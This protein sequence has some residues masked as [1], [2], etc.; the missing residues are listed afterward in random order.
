MDRL[1]VIAELIEKKIISYSPQSGYN[2]NPGYD[3]LTF[4]ISYGFED[5][6]ISQQ[7]NICSSRL[8]VNTTTEFIRGHYIDV[9]LIAANMSTVVNADFIIKL[10]Q[11]GAFGI[12]HRAQS[13]EDILSDIKKVAEK[14]ELVAASIGIDEE[15]FE[16]AKEMITAG[17]NILTIDVA[18]SYTDRTIDLVKKIKA[19][20]KDTKIIVGNTTNIGILEELYDCLDAVKV[21][22]AQGYACETKNTAG[23]TEKQFSAVYKFKGLSK[24]L[25]IPVISDGSIKEPA[26][27]VKAI[28]AG[29]NSVMA[30]K[31]FAACPESAADMELVGDNIKTLKK[32]YAG[33]ASRYVQER[34]KGGL[35]KGTCP[36]GGIRYLDIGE[37]AEKLLERYVGALRSGI[38]YSGAID[39]D[40]FQKNVKFVRFK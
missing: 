2:I 32:V 36:E 25:G 31:I 27:M 40:S 17:C 24:Y 34:W 10:Y 8:E 16:L 3:Q 35:R 4:P 21:G 12:I 13:K 11:L 29:A 15:Q 30:G 5:V 7:K 20:S 23:C 33:M 18:N 26:D 14:C 37:P 39:I 9:P 19:Y 1:Q 6:A 38:T 28:G 22:I